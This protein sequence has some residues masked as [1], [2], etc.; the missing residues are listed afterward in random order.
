MAILL[1]FRH[2]CQLVFFMI[3]KILIT[4][5]FY[6]YA[7]TGKKLETMLT[8]VSSLLLFVFR[9]RSLKKFFMTFDRKILQK[10]HSLRIILFSF[11]SQ[12]AL[13]CD[14]KQISQNNE[15]QLFLFVFQSLCNVSSSIILF[16]NQFRSFLHRRGFDR[17]SLL[18]PFKSEYLSG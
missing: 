18:T 3:R 17:W 8:H 2:F 13:L 5:L 10:S 4:F 1:R 9:I 16:P 6:Y 15:V 12:Y 7:L 14:L 11:W